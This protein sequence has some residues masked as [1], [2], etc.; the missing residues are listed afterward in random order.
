MATLGA[1][2]KDPQKMNLFLRPLDDVND[3]TWSIIISLI[4]LLM[5]VGYYI[6]ILLNLASKEMTDGDKEK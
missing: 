4:I 3:P 6:F 5:G 1:I 2:L